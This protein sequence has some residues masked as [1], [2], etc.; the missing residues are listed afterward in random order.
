MSYEKF[1]PIALKEGKFSNQAHADLP[2]NSYEREIGQ[3]GFFG[4]VTH[5]YHKHPPVMWEEFSGELR[6]MAFDLNL[7]TKNHIMPYMAE[8]ALVNPHMQLRYFNCAQNMP[9]LY[10]N[11]DGDEL[12]FVHKGVGDFF[13]DYGHL[14]IFPGDYLLIPR[15]TMWRLNP[16]EPLKII[17]IEASGEHFRLPS[18]GLV[19]QHAI[20]DPAVLEYP[21]IDQDFLHQQSQSHICEVHVKRLN[22]ISSIK[23]SFNPL[24]AMGWKGSLAPLKLNVKDIRPLMSHRYHLPPSAHTTFVSKRFVVCTF[25]PRPIESDIK[26]LKVPFFHNNDDFEEVIFYH[27]GNFFSRDNIVPGM[28]TFHPFGF[29]HGPHPQAF[30]KSMLDPHKYTDEVA[31]MIDSRDALEVGESLIQVENK[32]YVNSW[33]SNR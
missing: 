29:T 15:G 1:F 12:L 30:H 28:M 25:C 6:P 14:K 22:K 10:R 24:D 7:L 3:E 11:A 8:L 2:E 16:L 20:F 32:A 31:V 19:G 13:A 33:K 26:A 27:S 23:F 9:N 5:M 4:P 18:K 17:A 21:K